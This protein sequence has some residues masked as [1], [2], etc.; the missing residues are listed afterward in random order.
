MFSHVAF[1]TDLEEE[2]L[3]QDMYSW[4]GFPFCRSSKLAHLDVLSIFLHVWR[5]LDVMA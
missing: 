2:T 4:I 3:E 5:W 1:P